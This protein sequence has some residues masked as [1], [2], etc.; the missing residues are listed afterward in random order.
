LHL[1]ALENIIAKFDLWRKALK[2]SWREYLREIKQNSLAG[3]WV[4][5]VADF[6][7]TNEGAINVKES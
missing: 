6:L 7:I 4:K 2:I 3:E 5:E 1:E